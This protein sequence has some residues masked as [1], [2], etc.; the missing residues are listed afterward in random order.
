MDARSAAVEGRPPRGMPAVRQ[1][2]AAA[3]P[4]V[5]FIRSSI[6]PNQTTFLW[7][8]VRPE[9]IEPPAL[10]FEG[11]NDASQSVS[12]GGK[13]LEIQLVAKG[14]LSRTSPGIAPNSRSFGALVVQKY[15]EAEGSGS[16]A[17]GPFMTVREVAA[18]LRVCTA[19]VYILCESGKLVHVRLNNAIRVAENDLRRYLKTP[20]CR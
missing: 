7:Q 19:T 8:L 18:R 13:P 15:L 6:A 1:R 4:H 12:D 3:F 10:G 11:L 5:P 20:P 14:D 2:R 17:I 9:G 16:V